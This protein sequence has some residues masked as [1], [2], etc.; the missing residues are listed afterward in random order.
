RSEVLGLKWDSIDFPRNIVTIKHTVVQQ[1]TIELK[2]TTKSTS[3]YRSFPLTN[4]V[5]EMLLALKATEKENRR[6]FGKEYHENDYIFKRDDGTLFRPDFVTGKFGDLLKK[7]DLPHIR[8]HDLRHSCAS[9][10][11]SLGFSLKDI[12][13]WLGHADITTTANIYAH[14]DAKRKQGMANSLTSAVTFQKKCG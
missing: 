10:L 7:Y 12:Q 13:E 1:Q 5:R 3:S 6:L 4:D 11:I 2:D 8:F 14:L 9:L